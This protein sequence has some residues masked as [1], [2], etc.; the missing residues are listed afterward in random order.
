VKA[1]EQLSLQAQKFLN[2]LFF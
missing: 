2:F 1:T